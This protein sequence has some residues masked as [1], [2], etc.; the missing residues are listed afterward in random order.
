MVHH[1]KWFLSEV[2][3]NLY[4]A[5]FKTLGYAFSEMVVYTKKRYFFIPY[6]SY[7]GSS[8]GLSNV[9]NRCAKYDDEFAYQLL[10]FIVDHYSIEDVP[11]N[12]IIGRNKRETKIDQILN[13][14]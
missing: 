10:E 2:D 9:I 1:D 13:G 5:K 7:L 14:K 4:K 3:N 12:R 6:W 11:H 8:K